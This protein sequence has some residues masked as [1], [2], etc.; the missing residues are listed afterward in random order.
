MDW[1]KR[2]LLILPFDHRGSFLEKLFGIKGREPTEEETKEVSEYKRIVFDG[3]KKALQMGVEKEETGI[4]VDEQFGR[5]I[6]RDAKKEGIV[7]AMPVEKS[8]QEEFEFENVDVE[9]HIKRNDP[10]LVKVLVR[11]NPEGDRA[12]NMRQA[13]R[14]KKLSDFLHSIKRSY[15]FELLVPATEAQLQKA[16]GNGGKYDLEMRPKLMMKAMEELQDFG[17][18]PDVWKLEGVEREEDAK[19]LVKMAQR[20]GRNA[21]I[22]T[23]GRGESEEKVREWLKVGAGI[24]GII[25]FAVGRTVFWEALKGYKEKRM[26]REEAV[27]M[28]AKNYKGFVDLWNSEKG[29]AN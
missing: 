29:K 1:S 19:S 14:L 3:F 18:E 16:E 6:I 28:I 10:T 8:G 5:E 22:I 25:G 4:L 27:E 9:S 13:Q 20:N 12:A 7:V 15:L 21:G 2:A 23:L 24:D 17:V 26:S 11:Y